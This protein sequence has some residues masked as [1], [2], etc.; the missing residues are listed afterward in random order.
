M[1]ATNKKLVLFVIKKKSSDSSNIK[2]CDILGANES[3]I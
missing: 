3:A 2:S 1:I